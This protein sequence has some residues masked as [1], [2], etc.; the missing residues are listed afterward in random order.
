MSSERLCDFSAQWCQDLLSS[1]NLINT[2]TTTRRPD[3]PV[4]KVVTNS[5]FSKTLKTE[6]TIRAWQTLQAKHIDGPHASPASF[7]LLSL[8]RGLDSYKNILHGGMFGAIMDQ[9]TSICAISTLGPTAATVEMILR[10]K[11]SVS[12]P[13]VVLCITTATKRE[14]RKLW[15]KST[16]ENGLGTVFCEAEVLFV[17]GKE[18]KL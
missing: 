11:K 7:L 6:T 18:V 3:H 12:L 16:M 17:V 2:T 10:Y 13:G 5:L 4:D 8:G 9:A 15:L 1:P 14:G